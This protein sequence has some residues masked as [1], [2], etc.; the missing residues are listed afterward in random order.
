M[1]RRFT[2]LITAAL[3]AVVTML[4]AVPSDAETREPSP[5]GLPPPLPSVESVTDL[6]NVQQNPVV[7][8]R[9]GIQTGLFK[10]R[11]IWTFGD[12][13]MSVPGHDG[14]RW[15]ND[16]LSWTTDLDAADGITLSND[17]VDGTGAPVEYIPMTRE[18]RRYNELHEGDNCQVKPCNVE[19]AIWSGPVWPD[20]ARNRVLLPYIEIHRAI[21]QPD[22]RYIGTGVAVWTPNGQ[23]VRPILSP[24]SQNPTL[25]WGPNEVAYASGSAFD[26]ETMYAYGCK[27]GFLVQHCKVARVQLADA[28]D[29]SAYRY[30]TAAGM[31]SSNP[32]DAATIFDG[33][34]AGNTVFYS[35]YLGAYLAVYSAIYSDDVMYRMSYTPWG[36]WSNEAL[37]FT[38]RPGWNGNT[39]YA[40][41]AH[42]EYAQAEG[43]VQYVTY[44]HITGF[45][46]ADIPLVKIVFGPPP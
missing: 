21:G 35:P 17:V 12:T 18:E 9:D 40:A 31:W 22:W 10:G 28:L 29:K 25:M 11:S 32:A 5:T 30:Y 45:L 24:G 26:G 41:G 8:A 6:G 1:R 43:Q 46:R 23:V 2:G 7:Y 15:A 38:A 34:A 42:L 16:T 37:L 39:S 33:G 27:A 14:D 3:V 13:A 4:A 20:E 44:F 19:I 36:P